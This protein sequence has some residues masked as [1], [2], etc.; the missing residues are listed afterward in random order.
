MWSMWEYL[1]VLSFDDQD[2]VQNIFL[3]SD[4]MMMKRFHNIFISSF[5]SR[6]CKSEWFICCL[7]LNKNNRKFVEF[8]HV[9]VWFRLHRNSSLVNSDSM[10]RRC[11]RYVMGIN[12][13][14][15]QNKN[16]RQIH[17]AYAS[18]RWSFM[19]V[20]VFTCLRELKKHKDTCHKSQS[21]NANNSASMH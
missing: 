8:K 2:P 9:V 7:N 11:M 13:N 10:Q 19:R 20:N 4:S 18:K 6:I 17:H 5:Q 12:V 3:Y 16:A 1:K 15:T 14:E 21:A